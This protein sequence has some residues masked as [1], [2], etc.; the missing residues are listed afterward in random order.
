MSVLEEEPFAWM[1]ICDWIGFKWN[2]CNKT[3]IAHNVLIRGSIVSEW[4]FPDLLDS[5][6]NFSPVYL[7]AA[8]TSRFD[9]RPF[10]L[11]NEANG[12]PLWKNLLVTWHCV[13]LPCCLWEL[14]YP[15]LS[16]SHIGGFWPRNLLMGWVGA[17]H[18]PS[19]MYQVTILVWVTFS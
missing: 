2:I 18:S 14:S 10:N 17:E 19:S 5:R 3:S 11:W 4:A 13:A 1:Y 6:L 9:K 12:L 16:C 7:A 15:E 8:N